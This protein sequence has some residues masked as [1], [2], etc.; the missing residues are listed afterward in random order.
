MKRL[1]RI[2]KRDTSSFLL[3][4]VGLGLGI[5]CFVVLQLFVENE[6]SYDRFHENAD[7]LYRISIYNNSGGKE[8]KSALVHG[9]WADL[10]ENDIEGVERATKAMLVQADI[11][12]KADNGLFTAQDGSGFYA[13]HDFFDVFRLEI[14]HGSRQ[15]LLSD[16]GS[17]VLTEKMALKLFGKSDVVGKTMAFR[18]ESDTPLKVTGVLKDIPANSHLQ[19]DYI[20]AGST[21]SEF[22]DN[23]SQLNGGYT[24][25]VYFEKKPKAEVQSI[26]SAMQAIKA[27]KFNSFFEF[28]VQAVTDIHF[29][30]DGLF[31]HAEAGNEDFVDTINLVSFFIIFIAIINY[32][33]LSSSQIQLRSKEIGILKTLGAD[34]KQIFFRLM[35]ESL[36]LSMVAGVLCLV[37]VQLILQQA[38]P[39]WF[40]VQLDLFGDYWNVI[41]VFAICLAV[42]LLSGLIP[43]L[44]ITNIPLIPSLKGKLSYSPGGLNA[45]LVILQFAFTFSIVMGA[46]IVIKQLQYLKNKELGYSK[47]A[48][49]NIPRTSSISTAEWKL[50]S[51]SLHDLSYVKA[52]GN[53]MYDFIGDYNGNFL[54]IVEDDDTTFLQVQW[55]AIEPEVLDALE[56]NIVQGRNFDPS[57]T[58]DSSAILINMT[59]AEKLGVG[60]VIGRVIETSLT[61]NNK[62]TVIGIVDDFHFQSFDKEI[63]PIAFVQHQRDRW[64]R[65]LLLKFN[66]T[67]YDQVIAGVE[68]EWNR[69]GIDAEFNYEFLDQWFARMIANE[70][71]LG[72][73]ILAFSVM[74]ILIASLGLVGLVRFNM[75]R[76]R[77]NISVRKV[78][79][80]TVEG[81]LISINRKF[82]VQILIALVIA[83][84]LV[85]MG[86]NRW[87]ENF[88]YATQ[89]TIVD[90]LI[91]FMVLLVFTTL[92]I[93][94]QSWRTVNLNPAE[95][96]KD[97]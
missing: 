87:L 66:A 60:N 34:R 28:P 54:Q 23:Q 91:G 37:F 42:G 26:V 45:R 90:Y 19:F 85:Y 64:K 79:G 41:T 71:R 48:V 93:T 81:I 63:I 11:T 3:N 1:I 89:H 15:T 29:N 31:E 36:L 38:F 52:S 13:D 40:D 6:R 88:V 70:Q 24:T 80:A 67:D 7:E 17:I 84:P 59:A 72:N 86:I 18:Y 35:Y 73:L 82:V 5:G 12:L 2:I 39:L 30:A 50:F 58:S 47:E 27:D 74:S 76:Q 25:Y 69:L 61:R 96:L 22:W 65:N 20:V 44:R 10:L 55:N 9:I 94:I 14:L 95:V 77:K 16:P 8:Y 57:N 46:I 33:I 4:I 92:V 83:I 21:W 97:E 62:A 49:I 56:M 43:S 51:N 32:L 75:L 68:S 78:F 53:T